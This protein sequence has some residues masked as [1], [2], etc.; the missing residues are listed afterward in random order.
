[1][2]GICNYNIIPQKAEASHRSELVNQ[3]LFGDTYEVLETSEDQ[4]WLKIKT[5]FDEYEGFIHAKQHTPLVQSLI[6]MLRDKVQ[7]YITLNMCELKSDIKNLFIPPGCL[8]VLDENKKC[9]INEYKYDVIGEVA[10]F[11]QTINFETLKNNALNYLGTPY[12]WGGKTNFGID[13]SGFT[14]QVF[15]MSGINIW[16][17]AYQQ[18]T[19]GTEIAFE[20]SLPGDL[21]FF[22]D[23]EKITHVGIILE[24]SRIIHAHGEVRIDLLDEKGIYNEKLNYYSH[25]LLQLSKF[26]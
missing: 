3:L 12:L 7:S 16:R 17:D 19:Q 14:Q 18:A 21:A 26:K 4:T 9:I 5:T 23:A 13:C 2:I 10:P 24:D 1:M 15:K 22:G 25:K 8:L 20:N 6:P 11:E